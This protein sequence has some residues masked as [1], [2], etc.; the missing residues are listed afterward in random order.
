MAAMNA[1]LVATLLALFLCGTTSAIAAPAA[2]EKP[3]EPPKG[4]ATKPAQTQ[5]TGKGDHVGNIRFFRPAGWELAEKPGI[6]ILNPPG[7]TP[8]K[9]SVIIVSGEVLKDGDFLQW[10]KGKWT[11]LC[12][13]VPIKQGG[14]VNVEERPGGVNVIYERALLED[15][16]KH[17]TGLLL[18]AA[19]V[20]DDVEWA[21]FQT[22]GPDL[23]NKH[24]KAVGQMLGNMKFERL[25]SKPGPKKPAAPSKPKAEGK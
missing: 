24:N 3:M 25:E 20:G 12:Q 15:K 16:E 13:G 2:D 21:V 10:F 11:K 4:P 17:M 22:V 1:R 23:F 18:Y 6:A 14:E 7:E 5:P 19:Q 9:C 8:A